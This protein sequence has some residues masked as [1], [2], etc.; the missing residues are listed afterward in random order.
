MLTVADVAQHEDQWREIAIGFG[1]QAHWCPVVELTTPAKTTASQ[2]V[3]AVVCLRQVRIRALLQDP[4]C[5][6]AEVL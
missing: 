5:L 4:R 3:R 2:P 6:I 1:R